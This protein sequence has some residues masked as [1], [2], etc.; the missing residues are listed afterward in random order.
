[1]SSVAGWF[2]AG[3]LGPSMVRPPQTSI[4]PE[5]RATVAGPASEAVTGS[6]QLR[7][8]LGMRFAVR[9]DPCRFQSTAPTADD[10]VASTPPGPSLTGSQG[11]CVDPVPLDTS[12][13]LLNAAPRVQ[14]RTS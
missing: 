11:N 5:P 1:M 2:L 9:V 14:V 6:V 12:C 3:A 13:V 7:L 10:P 4:G 8:T